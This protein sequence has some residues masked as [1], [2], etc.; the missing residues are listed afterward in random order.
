MDL[1]KEKCKKVHSFGRPTP[2][3]CKPTPKKQL[4]TTTSEHKGKAYA[5]D[6]AIINSNEEDHQEALTHREKAA[7]SLNLTLKP[8]KCVSITLSKVNPARVRPLNCHKATLNP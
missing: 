4:W 6:L 8:S 3:L 1:R 7:N 5:D 2:V